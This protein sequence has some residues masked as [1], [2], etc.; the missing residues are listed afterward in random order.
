[1]KKHTGFK[2]LETMEKTD[3]YNNWIVG[4]IHQHIQ[5]D[6]LEVGFG[7]GSFTRILSKKGDVYA[8]DIDEKYLKQKKGKMPKYGY[9]DVEKGRYFFK[10]K[11]FNTIVCFNVLEHIKDDKK[12]LRNI[13][14]L[15]KTNG[16][17][18]I[19]LPAHQILFSN[20]DKSLGHYRRYSKKLLR[21]RLE[22]VG[23]SVVECKYV[24]WWAAIGWYLFVKSMKR[25][26]LPERQVII[27]DN[28]AKMFLW[29]ERFIEPPFGL[30]VLAI[31]ER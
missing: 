30:S 14:K 12:A 13:F 19:L 5:G 10:N 26:I 6:I 11:K 1:M 21:G 23:F 15:L 29:P 22:K 4:N 20:V 31:G 16:K 24:N 9:G 27:F 2:V 17:L 28:I 25:R 3:W 7:L 8:I 18:I